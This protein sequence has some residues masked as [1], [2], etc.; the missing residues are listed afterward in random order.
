MIQRPRTPMDSFEYDVFVSYCH[1]DKEWVINKLVRHL[2]DAGVRVLIDDKDFRLGA[3]V[4]TEMARAVEA[5]RYTLAVLTQDYIESDFALLESIFAEHLGTEKSQRRLLAI[6]RKKCQ[7]RLGIRTRLW[8]DMIDDLNFL[9]SV[10]RLI[11]ELRL[12]PED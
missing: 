4:V 5:S 3:L 7:P 11:R 2:E 12:P 6:M 1:Q 10:D 9:S 8:L